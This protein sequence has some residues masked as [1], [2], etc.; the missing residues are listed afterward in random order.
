[1]FGVWVPLDPVMEPKRLR[2][3]NYGNLIKQSH[4]NW[5]KLGSNSTSIKYSAYG[6]V[7]LKNRYIERI[8]EK[9]AKTA[10]SNVKRLIN[11]E[12]TVAAKLDELLKELE[13]NAKVTTV[14]I[15]ETANGMHN[16][17]SIHN[18]DSSFGQQEIRT[19]EAN[20]TYFK[21]DKEQ[22]VMSQGILQ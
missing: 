3:G 19:P 21:L 6:K 9:G 10:P 4:D 1:M 16:I 7:N 18:S 20:F 14:V 15:A 17:V 13:V 12:I 2:F 22:N 8:T 11:E 5:L